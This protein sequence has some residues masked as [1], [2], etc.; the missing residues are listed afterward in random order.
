MKKLLFFVVALFMVNSVFSQGA[1]FGVKAGVNLATLSD[2]KVSYSSVNINVFE[3]DGMA[4]GY[5][6]GVFANLSLGK[7]IGFQ[8]E[9]LFS[10]QGGKYKLSGMFTDIEDMMDFDDDDDFD[11]SK[12]KLSFQLGYVSVPLLLE[13]KP[14]ENL[15]ILVGPQIGYSLTRSSTIE[16]DGEK[17][18]ISGKDFD[19][20]FSD[21]KKIDV[22]VTFGIQY[23]IGDRLQI[24]ARYNL[25]LTDNYKL[26]SDDG[27]TMKGLR[28]GVI[29]ASIGFIF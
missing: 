19:D 20:E 22:G 29:Q 8:P 17:E 25:G 6:G 16:A 2:L 1:K 14:V 23:T 18:T 3:K 4:L 13:I 11:F 15:G 21:F 27:A 28:N 9:L 5:H 10:M 24:S 12:A 26:T 7:F